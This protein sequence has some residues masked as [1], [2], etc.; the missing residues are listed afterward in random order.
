MKG[1]CM[2]VIQGITFTDP[3][4]WNLKQALAS[5][6]PPASPAPTPA[7]PAP[8]PTPVGNAR[9]VVVPWGNTKSIVSQ[10]INAGEA[11]A[12]AITPPAGLSTG[13]QLANF[14][15]SPSDQNA[16]FDRLICLSA[17]PG[18]FDNPLRPSARKQG[19][20]PNVYFSVGGYPVGRLGQPDMS[21]ATLMPGTT[22]YVNVRQLDPT[23]ACR[24]N[25]GLGGLTS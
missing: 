22:Y 6:Q 12:F 16:Y 21:S 24:I 15:I 18:D 5:A 1:P 13:G 11:L 14:S 8:A 9:L 3:D 23:K 4:L 20:E 25:Y 2:I 10:T 19:Q 17:A 7:P